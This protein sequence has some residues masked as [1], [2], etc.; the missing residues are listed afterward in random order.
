MGVGRPT[1][2]VAWCIMTFSAFLFSFLF[3]F[4]VF[5][6]SHI[7]KFIGSRNNMTFVGL[8]VMSD[9]ILII[10]FFSNSSEHYQKNNSV[11]ALDLI[12]YITCP[13]F[14]LVTQRYIQQ[15]SL[16]IIVMARCHSSCCLPRM[17]SNSN[18]LRKPYEIS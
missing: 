2:C 17:C 11:K 6:T 18:L 16:E 15:F 8:S 13:K 14:C 5:E 3:L 10:D 7:K 1:L 12:R 4:C 9:I